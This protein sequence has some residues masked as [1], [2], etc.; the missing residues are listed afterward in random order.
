[1]ADSAT[2]QLALPAKADNVPLIRHALAGLAEALEM[3]PAEISDLKTV[4]TEACMNVVIHAYDQAAGPGPLEVRAWRDDDCMAVSVRDFG[5]GIRP[6]ADVEQRSLRLGLPLIAALTRSLQIAG[7]PGEGTEVRMLVP[8]A[9]NGD[10]AHSV[11][12][13]LGD[14]TRIDLPTNDLL[15]PVLSRLISM[16]AA[17]ADF[18]LDELSDAVLISDAI[19]AQGPTGFPGGTARITVSEESGAFNVRVGPLAEGGAQ[20]LVDGMRIPTF[21]AS[22][23]GLADEIKIDSGPDGDLLSIRISRAG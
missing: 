3:D 15:A 21:D 4:V 8:L 6:L 18:S 23:E 20:R 14:E 11:V 10:A 9:S 13:E 19:S 7:G 5:R 12:P 22:L 2:V 1:M 17:R 16:F